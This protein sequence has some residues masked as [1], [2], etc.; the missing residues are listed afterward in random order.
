LVVDSDIQPAAS[1]SGSEA[2]IGSG[3]QWVRELTTTALA[4]LVVGLTLWTGLWALG[5]IGDTAKTQGAK[6]LLTILL[7]PTGVVLGFYFGRVPAE[8]HATDATR[9]A[10][11]AVNDQNRMRTEA[12]HIADDL[13]SRTSATAIARGDA[14][15]ID[16][17]SIGNHLRGL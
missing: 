8:A 13:V 5:V 16:M 12:Q 4:V 1:G 3:L 7:G 10:E 6:D 14:A 15:P 17:R 11:V 9:R 2:T